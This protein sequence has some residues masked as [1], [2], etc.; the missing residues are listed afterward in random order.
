MLAHEYVLIHRNKFDKLRLTY[1]CGICPLLAM[2][3]QM[4]LR[5]SFYI[6]KNRIIDHKGCGKLRRPFHILGLPCKAAF[7]IAQT[8]DY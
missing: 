4:S 8:K 2:V 6:N 7:F 1:S 3:A 5:P